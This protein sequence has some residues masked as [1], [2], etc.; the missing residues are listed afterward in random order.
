MMASIRYFCFV[1]AAV[2]SP[3]CSVLQ[4]T[5]EEWQM[6]FFL[7]AGIYALGGVIYIICARGELQPWAVDTSE[8]NDVKSVEGQP[9]TDMSNGAKE[10]VPAPRAG[11]ESYTKTSQA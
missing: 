11:T 4:Q 10:P 8:I 7:A 6:V 2:T 3:C 1:H 5:R 9:L